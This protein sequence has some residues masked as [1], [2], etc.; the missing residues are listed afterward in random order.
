MCAWRARL[1]RVALETGRTRARTRL[2]RNITTQ[3]PVI[4]TLGTCHTGSTTGSLEAKHARAAAVARS[5]GPRF[6]PTVQTHICTLGHSGGSRGGGRGGGG[7]CGCGHGGGGGGRGGSSS[8]G[9]N[10]G[11]S[12]GRRCAGGSCRRHGLTSRSFKTGLAL[13]R[14]SLVGHTP[15]QS[16]SIAA[17]VVTRHLRAA[18]LT[19]KTQATRTTAVIIGNRPSAATTVQAFQGALHRFVAC[20]PFPSIRALTRTIAAGNTATELPAVLAFQRAWLCLLAPLPGETQGTIT[21]TVVCS[22]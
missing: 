13:A 9:S 2:V 21:P 10:C 12:R 11:R 18:I 20:F 7:G 16:S 6:L 5:N 14:T 22:N 4:G 15:C 3:H 17:S 19:R 8:S 1:T